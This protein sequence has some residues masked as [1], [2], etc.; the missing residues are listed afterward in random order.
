MKLLTRDA[1]FPLVLGL[2]IACALG[3]VAVSWLVANGATEELDRSI[4]L[5]SRVP[6]DPNDALGP[7]WFEEMLAEVTALGGYTILVIVSALA[8]IALGLQGEGRAAIF[9]ATTLIG[10]SIVSSVLKALF[11]RPRPDLVEHLDR[12]FTSSFPSAHAMVAT[13]A[14]LTLAAVCI[15]LLRRRSTRVFVLVSA[16]LLAVAIGASRVYLGVHW[17]SDVVAGWLAG[18]AWAGLAWMAADWWTRSFA[19]PGRIGTSEV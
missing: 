6:G 19:V 2:T 10:G 8:L 18:A 17:P 1:V 4:M 13:L 15:R 11:A 9:L 3:F 16:V 12:T 5:L 7:A 14:Y